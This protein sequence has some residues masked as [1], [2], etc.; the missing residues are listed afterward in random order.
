MRHW[1]QHRDTGVH[2]K[3]SSFRSLLFDVSFP[4]FPLPASI[5]ASFDI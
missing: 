5:P 1:G 4:P 3:P 2:W